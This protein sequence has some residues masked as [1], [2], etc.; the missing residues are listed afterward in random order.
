MAAERKVQEKAQQANR[1]AQDAQR[2]RNQ[3]AKDAVNARGKASPNQK[4]F[5][6]AGKAG[7]AGG[8]SSLRLLFAAASLT[9]MMFVPTLGFGA[10][11]ASLLLSL[12]TQDIK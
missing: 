6:A 5:N 3:A 8:G 1:D 11:A 10:F 4:A 9:S 2:A 7:R 12:S